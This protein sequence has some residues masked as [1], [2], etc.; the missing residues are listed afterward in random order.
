MHHPGTPLHLLHLDSSARPGRGG[1]E[2]HGSWSRRLSHAFASRWRAARP[3]DRYTY[4]DLALQPPQPMPGNWV[5]AAFTP[6]AQR[7]VQLQAALTES[8]QLVAELRAADVLVVGLPMYNYGMPA[9]LKA[10]ADLVVRIGETFAITRTDGVTS[11]QPLLSDRPRRALLVTSRGAMG[12]GAGGDYA[13]LNHADTALRA[14]LEFIGFTD[15]ETVAA[16]GE[17]TGGAVF[18][19]AVAKALEQVERLAVRW[20]GAE[21]PAIAMHAA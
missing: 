12:F 18:E 21:Q 7:S 4:R 13:A 20:S 15:I 3:H 8:D 17:E 9:A 1:I 2:P 6:P 19:A 10:W 11:Y 16:E 5:Q 14:V